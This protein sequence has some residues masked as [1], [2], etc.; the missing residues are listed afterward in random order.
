[1]R[2]RINYHM[3]L[4]PPGGVRVGGGRDVYQEEGG[5]TSIR[6]R[7]RD[8]YQEEGGAT[9]IRRRGRDVYQ[10][11]GA[12]SIRRRGARRLRRGAQRLSG[13]GGLVVSRGEGG[14][15][16]GSGRGLL[17]SRSRLSVW[18]RSAR[19]ASPPGG[20][21]GPGRPC[22]F[23]GGLSCP[24][25]GPAARGAA[26]EPLEG[27]R[28]LFLAGGA[29]ARGLVVVARLSRARGAGQPGAA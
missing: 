1:M 29:G 15:M 3:S 26:Y 22:R 2:I 4:H 13:G 17:L 9:S 8:V 14:A 10:E 6:R 24:P 19:L 27:Q 11:E 18:R 5:A 7:G 12:T 28:A 23:R 21:G 20:S 16:S 25:S